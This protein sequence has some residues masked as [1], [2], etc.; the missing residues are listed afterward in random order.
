METSAVF[1]VPFPGTLPR[2][3][4]CGFFPVSPWMFPHLPRRNVHAGCCGSGML[5]GTLEVSTFR[6]ID[7]LRPIPTFQSL[8]WIRAPAVTSVLVVHGVAV[9]ASA[10]PCSGVFPRGLLVR[11]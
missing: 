2:T 11:I 1:S 10:V 3:V 5:D 7:R 4:P 6:Q 9:F 8:R